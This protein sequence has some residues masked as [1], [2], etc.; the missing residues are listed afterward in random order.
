MA[1]TPNRQL[2]ASHMFMVQGTIGSLWYGHSQ[3]NGKCVFP[4][5]QN[6]F[7]IISHLMIAMMLLLTRYILLF[8]KKNAA[9]LEEA[10]PPHKGDGKDRRGKWCNCCCWKRELRLR[11]RENGSWRDSSRRARVRE[12]KMTRGYLLLNSGKF[13]INLRD[14]R[15]GRTQYCKAKKQAYDAVIQ[16]HIIAGS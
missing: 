14:R 2:P 10:R 7:D 13:M 8:E 16:T 5:P 12:N 15:V 4:V 11:H 1:L 6:R 9:E 3:A